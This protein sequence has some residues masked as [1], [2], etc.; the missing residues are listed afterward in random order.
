MAIYGNEILETDEI[1]RKIVQ[2]RALGFKQEEIARRVD[3]SQAS[4]S[5]RLEEINKIAKKSD[6]M[7]K[8]FW[9][10]ML[11]AAGLALLG[12]I[13]AKKKQ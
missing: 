9:G 6:D 7:D 1:D 5:Q 8:L 2:L 13:V 12:M 10:I 11:G 3:M 4:I